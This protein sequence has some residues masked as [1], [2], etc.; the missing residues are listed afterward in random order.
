[1]R[2]RSHLPFLSRDPLIRQGRFPFLE[3][4]ERLT[5]RFKRGIAVLTM[6]LCGAIVTASPVGR[7]HVA[8]WATRARNTVVHQVV[9]MPLE[10][11]AI[12]R[13]WQIKRQQGEDASRRALNTF[14]GLTTP[15]MRELF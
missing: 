11:A 1:M 4:S 8:L 3:R 13:E 6:L 15:E 10:R 5:Q 2:K 7:S 12:D 9:G 14:F